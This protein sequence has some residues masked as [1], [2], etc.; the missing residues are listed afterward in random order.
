MTAC[1]NCPRRTTEPNCH[2]VE[3]CPEWAAHMAERERVYA[4]RALENA[5]APPKSRYNKNGRKGGEYIRGV[6]RPRMP[7]GRM[8]VEGGG[9]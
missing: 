7:R 8:R 1:M 4:R 3:T 9:R 5:A 6:D 2:N